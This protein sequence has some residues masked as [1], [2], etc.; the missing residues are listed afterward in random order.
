MT[1]R[2]IVIGGGL[3]GLAAATSLASRGVP[4]TLLESRPRLGGRASSFVDHA[5]GEVIDNCQH[6]ILGCCTNFR[7][8]CREVG[9]SE[10]FRVEPELYFVARDGK[11]NRFSASSW[12]PAPLHLFGAFRRLSYLKFDELRAIASGL[13]AL[14]QCDLSNWT[15]RSFSEWL[16]AHRQTSATVDRFWNVVLVSALS[17]TPDRID[18]GYARKVFVDSFL[19][20]RSGWEMQLPT[21]PLDELYGSVVTD[22]LERHGATVRLQSGVERL[23]IN[24]NR[25]CGVTLRSGEV[26]EGT[27]FILAV[28]HE[29][30]LGMLPEPLRQH[31][32]IDSVNRMSPAP[33]TSVHLWFD[34]PITELPHVVL[35]DRLCQWVFNR[36]KLHAEPA[37]Q[38]GPASYYYQIVISASHALR[39]RSNQ[40]VV[41]DVV[42][43]LQDVWPEARTAR[44][45]HSRVVTEH[46][47]VFSPRPGIDALRPEQQSPIENLQFAGD[48]T[49][50]G[51]PATMEG[52]VRS[53]YLAAQN[54]LAQRGQSESL[55][56][57]DL[58]VAFLSRLFFGL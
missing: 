24:E 51:W 8:F 52:A 43:E 20:S 32:S 9:L 57:P 12:L 37:N 23:E 45:I 44:R 34:A 14:A 4:V 1:G 46:T 13:R 36:S 18:V 39:D 2:T 6:V 38:P 33:I 16:T 26:L 48:W 17:E 25:V 15:G 54:V 19:A 28:P 47:A 49:R 42:R 58:P 35:V 3:A 55:P 30:V 41:D 53:G 27:Q 21:V 5:T 11:V 29:R 10:F 31:P 22:Y 50:T 7:H 40:Q 56:Q